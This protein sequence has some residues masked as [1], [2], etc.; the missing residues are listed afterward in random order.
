MLSVSLKLPPSSASSPTSEGRSSLVPFLALSFGVLHLEILP[1]SRPSHEDCRGARRAGGLSSVLVSF[2]VVLLL[3]SCLF[4]A[5]PR[6][7]FLLLPLFFSSSLWLHS[8]PGREHVV[9]LFTLLSMQVTF[10]LSPRSDEYFYETIEKNEGPIHLRG[11]FFVGG[12]ESSS[13]VD[14]SIT[15]PDG[16]ARTRKLQIEISGAT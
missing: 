9:L 11:G 5:P 13:A 3:S 6:A 8:S 1:G 15:D 10:P 16:M 4:H 7:V 2:P 12:E 14:F